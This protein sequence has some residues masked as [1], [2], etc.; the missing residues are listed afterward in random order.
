MSNPDCV[1]EAEILQI[2]DDLVLVAHGDIDMAS[3]SKFGVAM[4]ELGCSRS[5]A[6]D[7]ADVTFM[8]SSGLSVIA[9]TL[10]RLR[11]EGG[12]LSV[13]NASPQIC[14]LLKITGLDEF[15]TIEELPK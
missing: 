11:R 12:A 9:G 10:R 3:A 1:F 13:R 15:L 6:L 7:P 5:V 2:G 14:R 4:F 8:N